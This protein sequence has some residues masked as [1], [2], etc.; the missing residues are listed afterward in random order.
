M[1]QKVD[2]RVTPDWEHALTL[3]EDL[4]LAGYRNSRLPNP[5]ELKSTVT[6]KRENLAIDPALAE[7]RRE[8]CLGPV[9][10]KSADATCRESS[11]VTVA[12]RKRF[13]FHRARPTASRFTRRS[14]GKGSAVAAGEK[15]QGYADSGIHPT[16]GY[17]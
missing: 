1:W 10:T 2:D 17:I 11:R 7:Y 5:E 16:E 6:H 13:L 8:L 4:T 9:S 3:A 12:G 15:S 14:E